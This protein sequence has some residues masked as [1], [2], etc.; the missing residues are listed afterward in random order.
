ML[1]LE[2][3][4]KVGSDIEVGNNTEV[5]SDVEGRGMVFNIVRNG[6]LL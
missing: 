2:S 3:N 6:C 5:R 1:L 4:I